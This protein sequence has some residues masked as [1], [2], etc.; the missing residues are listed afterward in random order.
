MSIIS[1][2]CSK[3][4]C[5]VGVGLVLNSYDRGFFAPAFYFLYNEIMSDLK[6]KILLLL[7]GGIAFGYSYTPNRQWRIL[8][9][10]AR[11]WKEIN[12]KK[13]RKEIKE[14][15][16]SKLVAKKE[17][18]DGSYTV[19]LTEKGK[20][21]ALTYHFKKMRIENKKWDGK[22]RMVVFDVPEKKRKGRD[23][24]REELKRIGFYELQRS[25]FI[26]PYKCK[27]EIDFV[28]EFF[29]L[30]KYVRFCVLESIDNELH[31]KKIFNLN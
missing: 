25:V 19:V 7:F 2:F 4:W 13:L 9:E 6:Q 27:D 20:L 8:K 3:V 26:F 16:R 29:Q 24:L 12:E 5:G 10:V 15:Y 31:L 30:R 1:F 23:A 14:L 22:W 18:P 28:I 11:A 17:N 21:R